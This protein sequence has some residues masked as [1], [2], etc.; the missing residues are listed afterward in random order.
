MPSLLDQYGKT[1]PAAE[2]AALRDRTVVPTL[3]GIRQPFSGHPADGLTPA[4]LAGI[5]RE[6]ANG[7]SLRYVELAEDIEERDLHYAAVLGTRRRSVSQLPITVEAASDDPAHVEHADL[8]RGWVAEG[9]LEDAL[10]DMTDSIGKGYAVLEIIW[11]VEAGRFLPVALEWRSQRWFDT[12]RVDGDTIMLREGATLLPL[13]PHKFLVH[14]HPNKSGLVMRSGI[15]RLCSWAWMFKAFTVKDWAQFVQNY[16]QPIRLGRY[17]ADSTDG[18]RAVLWRAVANIA[19]DCAAIVPK[20]MEIEFV[21]V[22]NSNDGSKLYLE[23]ADWLNREISKAVLGQVATTDAVSGGH[24]VSQEHR[25][26]QED[27]E[28]FDA[29]R[30]S[31]T[32]TRQLV[33]NIV[34]FNF[35]PQAAYPK[36]RIG[37]PDE[38]PLG[39]LADALHKLVPLGLRVEASQIRDRLGLEEPED[40]CEVLGPAGMGPPPK[41]G[42]PGGAAPANPMMARLL[43]LQAQQQPDPVEALTQRLA[44][45]AQGALAGL[46]DAVRAAVEAATDMT[47]LANRLA[48]LELD[49]AA[50]AAAIRGGLAMAHLAGEAALLD[51]LRAG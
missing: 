15:A 18:D 5:H 2:I 19:G 49:P 48:G 40:G 28:R 22:K 14:R 44:D 34:A 17:G 25:L 47:D 30:L 27:I 7:H 21:E 1:I 24:A 50:L 4:R 32:V 46:T 33:R 31:V 11:G 35:G 42:A 6:A 37:R 3:A 29:R 38:V 39:V 43:T 12:D 51:E 45:D 8:V 10:F 20:G 23:R 41:P 36:L 26:V 9:V 16:G 13:S